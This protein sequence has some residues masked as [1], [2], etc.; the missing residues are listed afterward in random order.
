MSYNHITATL[1]SGGMMSQGVK[2]IAIAR[3]KCTLE[4]ILWPLDGPV[5][6]DVDTAPV[7]V[8][9]PAR[10]MD[11]M[12]KLCRPSRCD[13]RTDSQDDAC[14]AETESNHARLVLEEVSNSR[15]NMQVSSVLD[16]SFWETRD[17]ERS[18]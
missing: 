6:Q 8:E 12:R 16:S 14:D 18:E 7:M 5:H 11:V 3:A 15:L 9:Q 10:M 2:S 1:T 13:D 17:A 4:S